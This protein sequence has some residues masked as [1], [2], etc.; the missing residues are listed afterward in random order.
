MLHVVFEINKI[1]SVTKPVKSTRFVQ[2]EGVG[3]SLGI[4]YFDSVPVPLKKTTHE[5]CKSF[6]LTLS[7]FHQCSYKLFISEPV[8]KFCS[9]FLRG[10]PGW[11]QPSVGDGVITTLQPP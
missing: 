9:T 11:Q 2:G 6:F 7:K 8:G 5:V 3:N 1:V 10:F 4:K